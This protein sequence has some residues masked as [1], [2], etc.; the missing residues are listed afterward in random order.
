MSPW[1][2]AK[3]YL[4]AWSGGGD[5]YDDEVPPPDATVVV[6]AP[7]REPATGAEYDRIGEWSRYYHASQGM[8]YWRDTVKSSWPLHL[9]LATGGSRNESSVLDGLPASLADLAGSKDLSREAAQALAAAG[10]G[11]RPR[12]CRLPRQRR[13]H[14]SPRST[15]RASSA[16]PVRAPRRRSSNSMATGW[17]ARRARSTPH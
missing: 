8:G 13:D 10:V 6:D 17:S 3:Y 16:S 1:Q 9:L 2:V 4:P 14:R 11:H 5:T 15:P 12:H 7:G